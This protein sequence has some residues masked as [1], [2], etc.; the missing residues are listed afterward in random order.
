MNRETAAL[1]LHPMHQALLASHKEFH[2]G[3]MQMF[4]MTGTQGS[5]VLLGLILL[6]PIFVVV[7]ILR[8]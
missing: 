6:I 8:S 2:V 3:A 5:Y 7:A 1:A 4:H